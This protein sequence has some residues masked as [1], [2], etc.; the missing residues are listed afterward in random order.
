MKHAVSTSSGTASIHTA[1]IAVG[2]SPGDEAIVSPI[3][4]M[5]SIAPLL[6]QGAIPV[7]ADVHP[8]RHVTTVDTVRTV[9]TD[10]PRAVIAVHLWGNPADSIELR[11]LCDERGITLIEDCA[12]AYGCKQQGRI[13]GT[14]GHLGAFSLN[15]FKHIS[16]GDA[17]MVLT[18]DDDLA[19][20]ARLA[21]DKGYSR[22][23][24]AAERNPTFL[25][26]N[27]RM[28]E[29]QGAVGLAQIKKLDSIIAR[30]QAWCSELSR[31]LSN[32]PGIVLPEPTANSDVS[33][34][35]YMFR[36]DAEILGVTA[37]DFGA[38]LQAE[39]VP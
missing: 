15:D 31:R 26:N 16:A 11:Q 6:W 25:C 30:R 27:Y 17:G 3:T 18:N 9:L 8:T 33:W 37:D 32:L 36:V 39:Q 14:I 24:D 38:A 22:A 5:G 23:K 4:D 1:L 2:V 13:A 29:L 20:R 7:F 28:T 12:Q 19:I 21:T 10:K 35:F 34:W